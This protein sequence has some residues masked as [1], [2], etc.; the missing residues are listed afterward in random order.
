M[1]FLSEAIATSSKSTLS[2]FAESV[3]L[4]TLYGRCLTHRRLVLA[5][6]ISE[7]GVSST[8]SNEFWKRNDWLAAAV[9]RRIQP[10]VEIALSP[11]DLVETFGHLLGRSAII[12]LSDTAANWPCQTAEQHLMIMTYE[13]R[14]YQAATEIAH[15][16]SALPRLSC[17]KVSVCLPSSHSICT[18]IFRL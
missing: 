7:K 2:P 12:H 8:D 11:C 3:V 4:T 5:T 15:I 17:L 14:A 16:A 18:F 10:F 13:Q 1:D 9:E 6:A